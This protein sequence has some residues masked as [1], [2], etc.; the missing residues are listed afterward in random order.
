MKEI[1][2]NPTF[3]DQTESLV[4]LDNTS[5]KGSYREALPQKERIEERKH[6]IIHLVYYLTEACN[7]R[8][9]YCY[10]EKNP[11][12]SNLTVGKAVVDFLLDASA[13]KRNLSIRFFGG[14]PIIE[15]DLI[16]KVVAY[17][18][19]K[20]EASPKK[21]SF[22]MVS[23]GTL[24]NKGVVKKLESLGV[25]VIISTDGTR[26]TMEQN[27]PF[28]NSNQTFEHFERG[29]KNAISTQVAKKARMTLSPSQADVIADIKYLI[30]LGYKVIQITTANNV[31]WQE[32]YL[33]QIYQQ[34][35]DFYIESARAGNVPPLQVTNKLLLNK[36]QIMHG[37]YLTPSRG[38]CSAGKEMLGVS[39]DG[40]LYLCHRFVQLGEQFCMGSVF[41]GVDKDKL[42]YF[43][44]VDTAKLHHEKCNSCHALKYCPGSCMA[45]NYISNNELFYPESRH[46]FDL[47]AHILAVDRIYHTLLTEQC[48]SFLS[49]INQEWKQK[50]QATLN[51]LLSQIDISRLHTNLTSGG[52]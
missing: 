7:L 51:S 36:H 13:D 45:A 12:R 52:E 2:V 6:S 41:S 25:R 21:I 27:R 34:I 37:K 30:K 49:F 33:E 17:A 9:T 23:N 8:C 50:R 4:D 42:A 44:T 39:V 5:I 15:L 32:Q 38:F 35:A 26:T 47:R 1:H 22:D 18:K 10:L 31:E 14:E 19:H 28:F 48:E 43:S 46:C 11:K 20:T 29:I 40:S 3:S 24:L 16:S